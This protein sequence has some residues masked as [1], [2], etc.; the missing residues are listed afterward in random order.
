MYQ[1][2]QDIT[3]DGWATFIGAIIGAVITALS[4]V[5]AIK[6]NMK[7]IKQ[8]K[9]NAMIPY[10]ESL[11]QSLPSYDTLVTQA[12]YLDDKDGLLGGFL[13]AQDKLEVLKNSINQVA[14]RERGLLEYKIEKQKEYLDYWDKANA[15]IESFM[16]DGYF[17]AVKSACNGEIIS[18]YYDFVVTFHN[19]HYYAGPVIDTKLLQNNLVRLMK[20]IDKAK[21]N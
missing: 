21:K 19:E 12:D 16:K 18:C 13:S 11:L 9:I 1:I 10:Y 17:N 4:I 7:Q 2:I 5:V 6:G 20:A 8:Q 14:E 15:K 3:P